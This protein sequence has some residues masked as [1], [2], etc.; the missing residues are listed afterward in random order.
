MSAG[1]AGGDESNDSGGFVKGFV[2]SLR[3]RKRQ[4]SGDSVD[5]NG[6]S[7]SNDDITGLDNTT[8]FL[9]PGAN[10]SFETLSPISMGSSTRDQ[11]PTATCNQSLLIETTHKW[12]IEN[13]KNRPEK[14]G[15]AIT[16]FA[17]LLKWSLLF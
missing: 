9:L 14:V 2:E 6:P 8:S 7:A 13:L 11:E 12:V 3:K 1:N 17:F 15:E 4:N 10:R 16:R 5:S